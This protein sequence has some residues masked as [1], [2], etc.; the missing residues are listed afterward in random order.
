MLDDGARRGVFLE[1]LCRMP[2][3]EEIVDIMVSILVSVIPC[4]PAPA[5]ASLPSL[6]KFVRQ[7]CERSRV[8]AGSVF[9]CI[10]YIERLRSKLPQT[11]KG[12]YCTAHRIFLSS[13]VCANKYC[14]DTP[15]RNK[16]WSRLTSFSLQE[17]NLMERQLLYLL[18][19]ELA[20]PFDAL[21]AICA[22]YY[23]PKEVL[24]GAGGPYKTMVNPAKVNGFGPIAPPRSRIPSISSSGTL[25]STETLVGSPVGTVPR[26]IPSRTG[27]ADRVPDSE[28]FEADTEGDLEAALREADSAI[29][30]NA[31][32]AA[33]GGKALPP[34]PGH[35]ANGHAL[36]SHATLA[37]LDLE[38][39]DAE[40]RSSVGARSAA[41]AVR[42]AVQNA[43]D[44][45]ELIE[46]GGSP[47]E[48]REARQ[49]AVRKPFWTSLR[50]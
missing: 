9:A 26:R 8:S 43:M 15:L 16:Q 13:L 25:S 46:L 30:H 38:I 23:H 27:L 42:G 47:G 34:L 33:A 32:A 11:A 18:E 21:L 3:T 22:R 12:M 28:S 20:I 35:P 45:I 39:G 50:A 14:N 40:L 37:S 6:T 1:R 5:N 29:R 31:R 7:M 24:S 41:G 49:H 17:V 10:T 48:V 4:A 36:H 19:F 44:A 2:V